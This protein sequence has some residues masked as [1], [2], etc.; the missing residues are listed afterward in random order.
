MK[1]PFSPDI[2]LLIEG[3][4]H[5]AMILDTEFRIMVMNRL[6]EAM[7]GYAMERVVGLHGELVCPQQHR[8]YQG[9]TL[10]PGT[11]K[12]RDGLGERRYSQLLSKKNSR[13][14]Y[15]F[16]SRG[17]YWSKVRPSC[18]HRGHFNTREGEQAGRKGFW[19]R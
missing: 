18:H 5:A 8:Q 11:A 13:A 9:A 16:N 1:L 2:P 15:R 10:P 4:P 3:I 19:F 12:R 14:V 17:W 6:M 7:T